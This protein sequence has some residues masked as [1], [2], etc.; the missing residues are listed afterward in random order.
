EING[1]TEI[2]DM[3]LR[4]NAGVRWVRTD[5]T[6]GGFVSIADPRNSQDPDGPGPLPATCP[7]P[8][9]PEGPRNGSCYPNIMN[10]VTTRN[11]YSNWL[12]SASAALNITEHA[13]VRAS[14]SRTMTRPDPSAMLPGLNFS[15]PSADV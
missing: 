1:D 14:V 13:I 3:R 4:Y 12:P 10:F 15:S 7:G 8:G 9:S 6:I 11:K 2:S 5:Q